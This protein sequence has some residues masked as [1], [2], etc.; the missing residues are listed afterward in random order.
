MKAKIFNVSRVVK[1]IKKTL[2]LIY[3][4]NDVRLGEIQLFWKDHGNG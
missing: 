3:K 4:K 1:K 2:G